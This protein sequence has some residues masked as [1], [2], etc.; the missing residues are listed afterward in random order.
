MVEVVEA[1][2]Q[3]DEGNRLRLH[4]DEGVAEAATKW[5]R[6]QKMWSWLEAFI[7]ANMLV[8]K[9]AW[10][11]D[12]L[13]LHSIAEADGEEWS[14]ERVESVCVVHDWPMG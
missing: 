3:P 4:T 8:V 1:W 14:K 2:Y 13:K 7:I 12:T 5:A 9:F 10:D 11:G 6:K